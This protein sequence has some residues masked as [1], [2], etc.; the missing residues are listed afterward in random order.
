MGGGQGA[1]AGERM[2]LL[3][4]GEEGRGRRTLCSHLESC[5]SLA[6]AAG[7]ILPSPPTP[8]PHPAGEPLPL[9]GH[10]TAPPPIT[11]PVPCGPH[12]TRLVCRIDPKVGPDR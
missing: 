9:P 10:S 3:L 2:D 8:L 6:D 7:R 5:P 4:H 12:G 11:T 1:A